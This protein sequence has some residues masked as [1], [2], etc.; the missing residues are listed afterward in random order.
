MITS[1]NLKDLRLELIADEGIRRRP[2]KDTLGVLTIGVGHNLQK[3]GLCAEAIMA[4]L[5]Y[6]IRTKC[7]PLYDRLYWLSGKPEVIQRVLL[8][9]AFQMGIE[10]VLS[11]KATLAAAQAEQWSEMAHHMGN[12]KWATQTPNRA[13]RLIDLVKSLVV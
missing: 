6:D 3:E 4:Q 12:S 9:M 11:F 8:N 7:L 10:G 1:S 5:D 13:K 2:Y